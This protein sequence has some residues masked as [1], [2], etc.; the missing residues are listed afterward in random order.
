MHLLALRARARAAE[1]T[2]TSKHNGSVLSVG[3]HD[4]ALAVQHEGGGSL[5]SLHH[6]ATLGIE[7]ATKEHI[8]TLY[9]YFPER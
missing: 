8:A 9:C 5:A 4:V 7:G 2:P 3:F 6:H 1:Q